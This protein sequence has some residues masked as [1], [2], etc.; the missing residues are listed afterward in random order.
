MSQTRESA[1]PR[2][3]LR[4][5][6]QAVLLQH[7]EAL[8][9]L[10]SRR[11][12]QVRAPQVQLSQ[13][14]RL[15]EQIAAHLDG[16]ALSGAAG[17]SLCRQALEL[18]SA[19]ALFAAAACALE[20]QDLAWLAALT[21]LAQALP[22][23]QSGLVS[24]LGWMPPARLR[25]IGAVLLNSSQPWHFE[26][27][28]A[29]CELHRVDPGPA[30]E[31]ALSAA[32]PAL[33]ARALRV[34][35]RLGRHDLLGIC[36][37]MLHDENSSCA[38]EA[39]HAALLLGERGAT[40]SALQACVQAHQAKGEVALH[41]LLL[42]LPISQARTWLASMVH[43]EGASR[44]LL[45]GAGLLGDPQFAPWL[46]EC[47]SE[48]ALARLAGESFSVLTGLD[49]A[50]QNLQC[51]GPGAPPAG[52]IDDPADAQVAL[53]EDESLPWPDPGRIAAW[54]AANGTGFIPGERSF[55]GAPVSVARCT[56]VLRTGFQRQR[57]VAAVH[58]C[59]LQPGTPLFNTAAPAWRQ[60]QWLAQMEA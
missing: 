26:L 37:D 13:L 48:P 5:P 38:F 58:L 52:S 60:Q 14:A 15:D 27:G 4:P 56:Q 2:H 19:G 7:V 18:P 36:R 43:Q 35:A 20:T 50:G 21:D 42:A 54:W 12:V 8:A 55:M 34:A 3:A 32:H 16:V 17:A 10:R 25:G 29:A 30:L 40:L 53:D 59:L 46:I 28:L 47:M 11:S 57:H 9:F 6:V 51:D 45:R 24:A 44:R 39:M 31:R 22:E 1:P 49:L 33:R 41:L 23:A